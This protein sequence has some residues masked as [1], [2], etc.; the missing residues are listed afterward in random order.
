MSFK[1]K[2]QVEGVP[3]VVGQRE[4]NQRVA[5]PDRLSCPYTSCSHHGARWVCCQKA[6]EAKQISGN[7][8]KDEAGR[9]GGG[10]GKGPV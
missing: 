4:N 7:E 5:G 3:K 9:G 6:K 2:D 10:S 8:T 1:A